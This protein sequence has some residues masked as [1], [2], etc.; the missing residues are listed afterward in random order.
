MKLNPGHVIWMLGF[1][2]PMNRCRFTTAVQIELKCQ[3]LPIV[4]FGYTQ[5][6]ICPP[7][8]CVFIRVATQQ[9][10]APLDIRWGYPCNGKLP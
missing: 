2:L 10:E 8:S 3:S 1:I 4:P 6:R 5:S 9:T 7:G